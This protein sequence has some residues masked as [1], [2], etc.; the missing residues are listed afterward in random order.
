MPFNWDDERK[1]K[2]GAIKMNFWNGSTWVEYEAWELE[3]MRAERVEQFK[4]FEQ[5]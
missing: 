5:F 2:Y 1:R 3:A 4:K